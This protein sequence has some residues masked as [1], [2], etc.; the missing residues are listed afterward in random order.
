MSEYTNKYVL[1]FREA[2]EKLEEDDG[3]PSLLQAIDYD[4]DND[5]MQH[6]RKFKELNNKI[7][8]AYQ[9]AG[10][11]LHVYK[12]NKKLE[13]IKNLLDD[14]WAYSYEELRKDLDRNDIVTYEDDWYYN[15]QNH[16]Y[17]ESC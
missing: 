16:D 12:G 17:R 13:K 6:D 8:D 15:P 7:F 14:V 3:N 2:V 4:A 11:L 5:E 1:A 9:I 10:D